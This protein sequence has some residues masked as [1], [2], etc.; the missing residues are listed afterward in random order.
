[1]SAP[2]AAGRIAVLVAD[3][4]PPARRGLRALL[5]RH[6]DVHVVGEAR[7]GREAIDAIGRLRPDLVVLY[8]QMPEGDG[9][10]VV[11]AVGTE[12]MPLVVFATAY[13]AYAV[14]AF[15][16][17]ALDYLLKPY[18]RQRLETALDR[19]RERLRR[20]DA[21]PDARLAALVD[22]LEGRTRWLDRLTVTAGSRIRLVDVADVDYFEAEMNYVRAHVGPRSH[23]VRSTLTA[24]EGQLDPARFLRVHRSLVVQLSRVAEVEPLFAGEYVLF[25]KDGRRLTTGRTYRAAVQAALRL[26]A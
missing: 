5:A 4:E 22:R 17:H 24:L 3:D 9:F 19:V 23:L 10:D 14:R 20:R 1:M 7:S 13:D 8:V 16:A 6:P 25:L 21:Q 26:R 15:E 2:P 12:R 18:D 11:R